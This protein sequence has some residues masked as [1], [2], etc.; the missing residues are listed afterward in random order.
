MHRPSK[1]LT[2][3]LAHW[4]ETRKQTLRLVHGGS[5][6]RG[7]AKTARPLSTKRPVHLVMR[8][9]IARGE[10]SFLRKKNARRVRAII[11]N[12]ARRFGIR[13][14]ELSIVDNHFHVLVRLKTRRQFL[15][16]LRSISGLIARAM[17]GA[18]RGSARGIRFW[19]ARPFTRIVA[20]GRAYMGLKKFIFSD[21]V[22]A[23]GFLPYRPR[24]NRSRFDAISIALEPIGVT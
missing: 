21:A 11:K 14:A 2:E 19:D 16:F 8:S 20:I 10:L 23:L 15:D 17:L 12:Q 5:L 24:K 9:S 7:N 3:Q 6:L 1:Q 22:S 13:V 18:E 4:R